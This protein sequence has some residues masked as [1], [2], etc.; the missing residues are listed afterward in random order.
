MFGN[1]D[2]L[3]QGVSV[4]GIKNDCTVARCRASSTVGHSS[5]RRHTQKTLSDRHRN[6]AFNGALYLVNRNI[7]RLIPSNT[8]FHPWSAAQ[9][10]DSK[11]VRRG[12]LSI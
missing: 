2:Q 12:C 1:L 6:N 11:P 5:G 3:S 8:P 7:I 4:S 10:E 9:E